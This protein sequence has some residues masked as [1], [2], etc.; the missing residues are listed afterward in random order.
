MTGTIEWIF[1]EDRHIDH[2]SFV[3]L[4]S[5]KWVCRVCGQEIDMLDLPVDREGNLCTS[6][7][8][9]PN[10]CKPSDPPMAAIHGTA[11]VA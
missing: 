8:D 10:R 2:G 5:G 9:C 6:L 1:T 11:I 7:A 3:E 4:G